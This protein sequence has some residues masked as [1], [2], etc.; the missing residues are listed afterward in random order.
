MYLLDSSVLI[1]WLRRD[2][3]AFDLFSSLPQKGSHISEISAFE[4]L[5]G[6]K[7]VQQKDAAKK[8]LSIFERIPVGE[9]VV[10]SA[11]FLCAKYPQV[12]DRNTAHTLFDAFIAATGLVKN[13]EVITLNI[14]QFVHLKEKGLKIRILDNDAKKWV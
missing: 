7:S 8:L 9:E 6:A 11:V 4:I 5:I 1:R 14:R 3:R 10:E 12:F 2:R 13:L